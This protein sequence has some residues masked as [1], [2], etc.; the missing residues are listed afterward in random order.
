M[1]VVNDKPEK[2]RPFIWHGVDLE[3]M[4][5]GKEALGECPF[6]GRSRKLSVDISTGRWR[7]LVNCSSGN[8]IT[9]IRKLWEVSF[10]NTKMEEYEELKNDRKLLEEEKIREWGIC[11]SFL[12]NLWL[13][14][15]GNEKGNINNLYTYTPSIKKGK[16]IRLMFSTPTLNHGLFGVQDFNESYKRTYWVEGAWDGIALAELMRNPKM[17]K[18]L[19]GNVL[20]VPGCGVFNPSWSFYAENKDNFFLYDN[21]HPTVNK[22][23]KELL[24]PAALAGMKR[25]ANVIIKSGIPSHSVNYITWGVEGFNE[26][27]P[28]GLDLRDYL[29]KDFD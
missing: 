26:S 17:P 28:E 18:E 12:N 23:T 4:E 7:C 27:L 14:P 11:K 9:F 8:I 19:K 10:A 13:V 22:K 20:G 6:C 5:K 16:P 29:I 2:L 15:G 24:E 25:A 3:Y 21:D 1:P